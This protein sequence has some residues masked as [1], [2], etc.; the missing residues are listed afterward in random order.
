MLKPATSSKNSQSQLTRSAGMM[1][2]ATALSRVT[3]LARDILKAQYFGTGIAADAFTVAFRLPNLLRRLLGEG[4]LSAAFIPVYTDYRLKMTD[5]DAWHLASAV[6][7]L[8][9]V[10][11]AVVA[12]LGMVFAEPLVHLFAPGFKAVPGKIQLTVELTR[13]LFP[14]ILFVGLAALAMALLNTHKRFFLPAI[15][16]L[17]L[18][19][20]MILAM[21]F[22]CP[23]LGDTPEQ[24]IF[25]LAYGALIGGF[26][27]FLIQLPVLK[28]IGMTFGL[29]L[30]WRHP[31]VKRIL[32]LMGPGVFALGVSQVNVF[33]DT[34][35]ASLLEEGSVAALEYANRLVQLP[36]GVFAISITTAIL[37]QLSEQSS[38][39]DSQGLIDTLS[40]A[41][42]LIFFIMLPATAG[43]VFL[44]TPIIALVYERGAFGQHSTELTS[45]ALIYYSIGLFAYG[46]VKAVA[47]VF[48]AQKDTK[49]PVKVAAVAMVTN[50]LLNFI[51]VKPL[52]LGGLALATSLSSMINM[53]FL[54]IILRRRIGRLGGRHLLNSFVKFLLLSLLMGCCAYL[55]FIFLQNWLPLTSLWPKLVLTVSA[56]G[57][58][59]AVYGSLAW[60]FNFEEMT[61]ILALLQRRRKK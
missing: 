59:L 6:F 12:V 11:L 10:V 20:S 44:R 43:L 36:L 60:F 14:Y 22:W 27:Q 48:Y 4:A 25:G 8:F 38:H 7:T 55:T 5:D 61:E 19:V 32:L 13:W 16:P 9:T 47:Q 41:L 24:Q 18:N 26:G 51:L 58:G 35:L 53:S 21:I 45:I 33:V 39:K 17:V 42:R 30:N 49:T 52:A 31:G 28:R 37:P 46:G 2:I 40:Y 57:V 56:I 23:L 34:F 3:G 15:A 50:I 29:N 54:L 1:T